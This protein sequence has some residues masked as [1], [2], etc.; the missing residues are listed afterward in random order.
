MYA[1]RDFDP[2]DPGENE[3]YT[4]DFV[5][6]L[7]SNEALQSAV[8]TCAAVAGVDANAASC[9]IGTASVLATKTS[10][11]ISGL[12]PGVRYLLQAKGVT[13][14]GNTVSLYSHA[15]CANPK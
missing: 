9:V 10:Q 11:R 3:I 8:W 13:N 15:N 4:F 1:G 2:A 12:L 6:D 7:A 5:N 14:L